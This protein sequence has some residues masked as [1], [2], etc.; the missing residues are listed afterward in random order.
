[1]ARLVLLDTHIF[2][3]WL[4]DDAA[5]SRSYR[6]RIQ[7][8]VALYVSAASYWEIATKHRIGKLP[9]GPKYLLSPAD[10]DRVGI[11]SLP[12]TAED[13]ASSGL[14]EWEHADPFDR[15][16]VIQAASRRL[17]LLTNDKLITRWLKKAH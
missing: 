12:L 6:A 8:A 16:L 4:A 10:L 7:E 3:W 11:E 9:D 5:L 14:L 13:A 1:M 2:M 15:M 17:E